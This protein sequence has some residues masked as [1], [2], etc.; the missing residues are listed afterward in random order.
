MTIV[1][2]LRT[3]DTREASETI[4]IACKSQPC[5]PTKW[6]WQRPIPLQCDKLVGR[7]VRETNWDCDWRC[8]K[9]NTGMKS[10]SHVIRVREVKVRNRLRRKYLLEKISYDFRVKLRCGKGKKGSSI[11]SRWLAW[12]ERTTSSH[13]SFF[14]KIVPKN[15]C[16]M[17]EWSIVHFES[18]W[19]RRA[20][21]RDSS[22]GTS[23]IGVR[24]NMHKI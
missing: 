2:K 14:W 6:I 1:Y 23:T 15:R 12:E 22:R 9:M 16:V 7:D 10:G 13:N 5:R 4:Q 18:R 24:L 11:E 19:D 21:K 17:C 20:F 3:D 8:T